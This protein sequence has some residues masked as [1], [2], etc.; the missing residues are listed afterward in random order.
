MDQTSH[1]WRVEP[2]DAVGLF[3]QIPEEHHDIALS[4]LGP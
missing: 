2:G 3:I 4:L 1:N